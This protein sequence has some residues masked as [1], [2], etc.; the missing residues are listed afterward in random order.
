MIEETVVGL[1]TAAAIAVALVLWAFSVAGFYYTLRGRM[2]AGA[3]RMDHFSR[4]FDEVFGKIAKTEEIHADHS[5][6]LVKVETVLTSI[7]DKLD[8]ILVEL[9]SK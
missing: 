5:S 4:R 3:Q 2:D 9:K 6:R 8:N 1:P 7:S